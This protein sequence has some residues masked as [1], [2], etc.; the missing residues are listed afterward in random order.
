[1]AENS[2]SVHLRTR[3]DLQFR[4]VFSGAMAINSGFSRGTIDR[5]IVRGLDGLPYLPA[6]TLKGRVRDMAERLAVILGH[7]ICQAP[8]PDTTCPAFYGAEGECCIIC[9][10]FGAPGVSSK[11]GQT[12][13]IWRDAKLEHVH[14]THLQDES[15]VSQVRTQVQL[16]RPRGV[17]LA[18]HLFTSENTLEHLCFKGRVRGW[19]DPVEAA[20]EEIPENVILLCAALKLLNFIGSGK[21]RGLGHCKVEFVGQVEI[22]DKKYEPKEVLQHVDQLKRS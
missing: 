22:G 19:I 3:L 5:T 9:R 12:G 1:M 6:S 16:S 8:N 7:E 17:S 18:K 4:I 2:G 15:H 13:L 20:G 10:T 21:S 14:E 11:S